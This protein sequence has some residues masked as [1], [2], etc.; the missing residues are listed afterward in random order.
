MELRLAPDPGGI[1][2]D[3]ARN[4][5]DWLQAYINYAGVSEAPKYMHFWCGV[6]A[7]AGVLQ[8]KV[9]FNM[10]HFCW[11]PNFYI[12][13]V[14]PPGIVAK[15]STS[16]IAMNLL[17]QIP[18][19]KFGPD[20]V[21]W[22]ALVTCFASSREM[23]EINSVFHEMCCLTLESSEFGNLLD[24]QDRRMV[25]LLVHLWDGKEGVFK[26]ETKN[27]GSDEV[28]NPWVNI[29]ACTT[30]AWIADNFP[31]YMIGGG[32]T[33]RC[34]FVYADQKERIL[35]YPFLE[36]TYNKSELELSLVEDLCRISDLRGEFTLDQDALQWGIEWY[37]THWKTKPEGLDDSRF[38]GYLARKQSHIHKL[39]MV[40][41]AA[42]GDSLKISRENLITANF[43]TT[44]LEKDMGNVFSKIGKSQTSVQVDRILDYIKQRK[45]VS[46]REVYGYIHTYFPSARDFEDVMAGCI[47]SGKVK[48]FQKDGQ[49]Y[50]GC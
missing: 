25:D 16:A 48:L 31:E 42:E 37:N 38:G 9:W 43:M 39:A 36:M 14:A 32:F 29:I 2:N 19:V 8:R 27:S 26:K 28:V 20:V 12:I 45:E 30:P 22:Q 47:K 17:K 1:V 41:S 24:P 13:L 21:T 11:Y 46:Y 33:S 18:G 23:V 40:L 4:H 35:A 34:V 6:S 10:G 50:L 44:D 7:I 5:A 49:P 15:S 3:M